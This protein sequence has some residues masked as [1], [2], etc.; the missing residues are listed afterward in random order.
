MYV[1]SNLRP[2]DFK[3]VKFSGDHS[4]TLR[5]IAEGAGD[6]GILNFKTYKKADDATKAK[7]PLLFEPPPY[8]DYCWVARNEIGN[9]MIGKIRAALLKLDIK[10]PEH[11]KVLEANSAEKF[12]EAKPEYWDGCREIVDKL[13]EKKIFDW[14]K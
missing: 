9:D 7:A 6:V 1:A 11:A 12:I 2:D 4:S 13:I 5:M 14:K 3:E 8:V 10:N